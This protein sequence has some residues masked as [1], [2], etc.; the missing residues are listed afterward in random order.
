MTNPRVR[1]RRATAQVGANHYITL[2][3][4]NMYKEALD[5]AK[6]GTTLSE[7]WKEIKHMLLYE[8]PPMSPG[9]GWPGFM[10]DKAPPGTTL[11][12][13]EGASNSLL[14]RMWAY[15]RRVMAE[16]AEGR[17]A[18]VVDIDPDL[19][20]EL[21]RCE[22]CGHDVAPA[23]LAEHRKGCGEIATL[24]RQ[25]ELATGVRAP[26]VPLPDRKVKWHERKWRTLLDAAARDLKWL[27]R[28]CPVGLGNGK[29]APSYWSAYHAT[30]DQYRQN[31]LQDYSLEERQQPSEVLLSE[32]CALY[33]DL[34]GR[35]R[36]KAGDGLRLSFAWD[37]A[38]PY[39]NYVKAS[40][41][42]R[43]M[44]PG[45]PPRPMDPTVLEQ[46]LSKGPRRRPIEADVEHGHE[47]DAD[48]EQ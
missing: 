39:L 48:V 24:K 25:L 35:L 32:A 47:G 5:A 10:R 13:R 14:A 20:V 21:P 23:A 4:D 37:V 18:D 22:L 41:K 9:A 44:R 43:E 29:R 33:V 45:A 6:K 12:V 40:A 19:R 31:L 26:P 46:L 42:Q 30:C 15:V 3:L 16:D 28:S 27:D 2:S 11:W 17:V 36:D 1:A 8:P 7:Q 34:Y 38:G